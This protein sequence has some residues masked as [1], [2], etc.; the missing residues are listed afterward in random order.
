MHFYVKE[1][2]E[3]ILDLSFPCCILTKDNWNDYGYYTLFS[4]SYLQN[5]QEKIEIGNVKIIQHDKTSPFLPSHFTVLDKTYYSLGQN[6]QY[7]QNLSSL[8]Y[9]NILNPINDIVLN[10]ALQ[11]EI[12]DTSAYKNSLTRF[13]DAERAKQKGLRVLQS[14]NYKDDNF[15]FNFTCLLKHASEKHSVEFNFTKHDYLPYRINCLIGKN[16]TGKT[17]FISQ[18][19]SALSGQ[20]G[21]RSAS[22]YPQKPLFSRV[23]AISYSRFDKFV[24]PT[25]DRVFSYKYSGLKDSKGLKSQSKFIKSFISSYNKIQKKDR[26]QTWYFFVCKLIDKNIIDNILQQIKTLNIEDE[27]NI[28]LDINFSSGQFMLLYV[29]TDILA[30]I[31]EDSLLIFD[32]PETHLHPNATATLINTINALLIHYDSYA[33]LATHS[34]LIIQEIPSKYVHVFAKEGDIPDIKTL[35]TYGIESF[36]ENLS[37]INNTIFNTEHIDNLYKDYLIKISKKHTYENALKIFDDNL[38]F[39]AKL[40]LKNQYHEK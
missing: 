16:G 20:Q 32:E 4:L 19:A 38:S 1:K 6:L 29:L 10:T 14:Q 31:Q 36:G 21:L 33:I 3:R 39:N 35:D 7:Y 37:I 5:E 40:Y 18:L 23:I 34:P 25:K 8:Q 9:Q 28:T 2:D 22:F 13:S 26:S 11:E 15:N 24:R 12:E 30:Y 27:D 17:Q